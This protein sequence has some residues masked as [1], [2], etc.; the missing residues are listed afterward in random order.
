MVKVLILVKTYPALSETYAEVACTAGITEDGS[1]IRLY[2]I[3]FRLLK[4]DQRYKKYQW[5][6]VQC[7]RNKVDRRPESHKIICD[8]LR[9]LSAIDTKSNWCERRRIILERNTIHTDLNALIAQAKDNKLSLAIFKPT[10][11]ED[12][13]AEPVAADWP[14]EK[15]TT[16]LN[17]LRQ[18]SFLDDGDI[19][20]FKIM[21]K[22]PYKFSYQFRDAHNK[23]STLMIE[24][25]EIGQLYWNCLKKSKNP[26][27]AIQKVREKYFDDFA[28]TKDLHFFLGTTREWHLRAPNPF[29]I[30]G[31][32]H[33]P[34]DRQ[35]SF[36]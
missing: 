2:P 35:P 25:W 34:I 28:K 18:P 36:L 27:Q 15:L 29:I 5:V 17:R 4:H 10:I 32:F 22:L 19:A 23:K 7:I 20:D 26:Q 6:E 30:V 14:I 12:F 33:P 21:P 3:P 16:V 11:I 8:S 31:T 9:V 13:L 24:D 1:W